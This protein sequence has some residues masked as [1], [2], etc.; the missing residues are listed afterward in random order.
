MGKLSIGKDKIVNYNNCS[1]LRTHASEEHYLASVCFRNVDESKSGLPSVMHFAIMMPSELRSYER[2]WIGDTWKE[3]HSPVDHDQDSVE[4]LDEN[5][6]TDYLREGFVALQYYISLEYLQAAS[7]AAKLPAIQ[8][9][10]FDE[11]PS[12]KLSDGK[13]TSSILMILIGFMFPVA[14]LVKVSI[15][16]ILFVVIVFKNSTIYLLYKMM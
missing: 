14:I 11:N 12:V 5:D 1:E 8:M 15:T 16:L 10:R 7:K 13:A 6:F 4:G 3:N 2:T 9:R